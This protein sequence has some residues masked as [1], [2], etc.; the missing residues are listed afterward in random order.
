LA[1]GIAAAAQQFKVAN[2][3]D[4]AID[5]TVAS[6]SAAAVNARFMAMHNSTTEAPLLSAAMMQRAGISSKIPVS[7][8]ADQASP[9]ALNPPRVTSQ[10][11][12]MREQ[13]M[14]SQGYCLIQEAPE[15][16]SLPGIAAAMK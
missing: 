5:N 6:P 9:V 3:L 12:A 11:K 16:S 1:P 14:A 8:V 10:F 4:A 15:M 13:A 7:S 2:V